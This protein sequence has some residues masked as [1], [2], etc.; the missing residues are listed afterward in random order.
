MAFHIPHYTFEWLIMTADDH[1]N[2]AWHDTSGIDV[3]PLLLLAMLPAFYQ[4][5]LIF[6]TCKNVYP[7][8]CCKGD[9]IRFIAIP[10]FI[11][12]THRLKLKY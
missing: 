10:K 8:Y 7:A 6:V 9:E 12:S 2:E 5:I 3:K 4:F 11:F 1:V